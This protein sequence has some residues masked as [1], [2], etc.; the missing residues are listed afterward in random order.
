MRHGGTFAT[1]GRIPQ[2][3]AAATQEYRSRANHTDNEQKF[4]ASFF[5]KRSLPLLSR[6]PAC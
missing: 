2:P 4:F 1:G 3:G 6:K 5:Q